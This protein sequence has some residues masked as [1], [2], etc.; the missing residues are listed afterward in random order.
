MGE[1]RDAEV[2]Q[3]ALGERLPVAEQDAFEQGGGRPRQV[4][5]DGLPDGPAHG[6]HDPGDE[7]MALVAA[8]Q[9]DAAGVG[10]EDRAGDPPVFRVG[11]AVKRA[12]VGGGARG[13]EDAG[14][15]HPV[16]V[17]DVRPRAP[18]AEEDAPA[19]GEVEAVTALGFQ[20]EGGVREVVPL[21]RLV[22]DD[23]GETGLP[24]ES[25]ARVAASGLDLPP[26]PH[27]AGRADRQRHQGLCQA[28]IEPAETDGQHGDGERAGVQG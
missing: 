12:G 20:A 17:P 15:G 8:E 3:Q 27:D 7:R 10:Q 24:V 6:E 1:T 13:V 2:V 9:L 22:H 23:A 14:E 5:L 25:G 18:D 26:I 28:V 11:P 4:A 16:A 19:D 21:K